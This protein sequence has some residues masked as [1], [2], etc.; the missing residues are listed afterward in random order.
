M[1]I[2]PMNYQTITP[3]NSIMEF[4]NHEKVVKGNDMY[5]PTHAK[6]NIVP[7]PSNLLVPFPGTQIIS[8]RNHTMDT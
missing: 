8:M 5:V 6:G 3:M 2:L 7:P 1:T 4:F